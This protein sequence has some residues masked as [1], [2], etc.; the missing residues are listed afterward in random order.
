MAEKKDT[1]APIKKGRGGARPG[2]GRPRIKPEDSKIRPKNDMR[3]W[4][5][6]WELLKRFKAC[7]I[8]NK[9][10]AE[11]MLAVLENTLEKEAQEQKA[12]KRQQKGRNNDDRD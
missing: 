4:P 10:A 9:T 7:I 1:A 2:A 11:T 8:Q 5:D 6:E 3:A 12:A